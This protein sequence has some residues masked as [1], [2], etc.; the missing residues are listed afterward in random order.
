M[1]ISLHTKSHLSNPTGRPLRQQHLKSQPVCTQWRM[2]ENPTF[3]LSD[4]LKIFLLFPIKNCHGQQNLW[5]WSLD[6]SPPSPQI[7]QLPAV[8]SKTPSLS[9]NTYLKSYWIIRSKQPNLGLVTHTLHINPRE[10]PNP[11]ENQ[12]RRQAL[13]EGIRLKP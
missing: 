2:I 7:P 9:T 12:V 8:L 6:M 10:T 3:S 1:S 11:R 5:S 4:S 13:R